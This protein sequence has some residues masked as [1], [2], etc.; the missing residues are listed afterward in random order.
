MG[1]FSK[2]PL[3]SVIVGSPK[4]KKL[5]QLLITNEDGQL[6]TGG[7]QSFT[8]KFNVTMLSQPAA[9]WPVHVALLFEVV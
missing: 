7:S 3:L 1:R 6:I 2:E 5:L 8:V 9:F 4:V